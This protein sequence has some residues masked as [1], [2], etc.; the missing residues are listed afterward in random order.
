MPTPTG[1]ITSTETWS[2]SDAV[3]NQVAEEAQEDNT[4]GEADATEQAV[5]ESG[6]EEEE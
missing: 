5:V 2:E 6:S 3:S 4:A 1:D